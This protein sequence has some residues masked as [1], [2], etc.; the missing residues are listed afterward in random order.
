M[1]NLF[2][3]DDPLGLRWALADRL[4]PLLVGAMSF[5]AALAVAGC[6][7]AASL[8]GQWQGDGA[9]AL[10]IQIPDPQAAAAIGPGSRLTAVLGLLGGA[11]GIAATR[12]LST[13]E[14]NALLT[15]WL[16]AD[17][18]A[19]GLPVPAII[20]ANWTGAGPPDAV[21]AALAR[22]APGTLLSSGTLWAARV[23]ALT[24]SLQTCAAAVLIIVAG[25]AA[26]II[27]IATRAG[28]AQRREEVVIIHSLG[29]LD[30][31]IAG[32]FADRA[33]RLAG[34]GGVAGVLVALPV[35]VWLTALA[36][37]FAGP[38]QAGGSP[39]LPAALWAVLP[40]LPISAALIG[41]GTAQITVRGWLRGLA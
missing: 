1:I 8:A 33:T 26:A 29:A 27:A 9:S 21:A 16:G 38:A 5:I 4:L 20:T 18:G 15:P 2:A 6:L 34:V 17:A 14:I 35:L 25:I 11:P 3:R 12:P 37:P 23:A 19:L 10:T 31:D 28:L 13:E 30:A 22:V 36:A 40:F 32:R 41:W 7:A 24:G 39:H